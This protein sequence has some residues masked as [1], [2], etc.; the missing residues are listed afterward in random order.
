[1]SC[2][3]LQTGDILLFDYGG[4]G[5]SG[6]FS[7]LIK[8]VT[9]SHISH[10]AMVLK[11]P[12]FIHPTLKGYYVWESNWE[13]TPDPQ[14]QQVKFG[15]QITPLD[16]I[17]QTYK[18]TS[19]KIY[20]RKCH[21][22]STPFTEEALREA[23]EVVYN[24]VYDIIPGDWLSAIWHRDSHPQKTDRF[25]CSALLGYIYTHCGVLPPQT[26]WS[27]L[28]PSDFSEQY[29]TLPLCFPYSLEKELSY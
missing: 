9:R 10:V 26:D 11:D 6:F 18:K 2:H 12:S 29:K 17:I 28:R 16:Q 5:I 22:L 13:G 15:V 4:S 8:W 23:H 19:S 7:S 24:K 1:M 3:N 25:W 20:Y 27:L 21:Y 14:D